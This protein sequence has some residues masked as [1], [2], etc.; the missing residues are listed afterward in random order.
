MKLSSSHEIM[1]LDEWT[2]INQLMN[3][4]VYQVGY[5]IVGLGL[6]PMVKELNILCG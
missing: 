6:G 4:W 3:S 2:T 5:L 1:N